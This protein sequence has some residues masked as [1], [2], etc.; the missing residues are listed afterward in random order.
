MF[1]LDKLVKTIIYSLIT[2]PPSLRAKF[3]S[4]L[5]SF[6]G[7][8]NI[9]FSLSTLSLYRSGMTFGAVNKNLSII[10]YK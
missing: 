2:N 4:S 1:I 6:S 9:L 5:I 8:C 10:F 7:L 3:L